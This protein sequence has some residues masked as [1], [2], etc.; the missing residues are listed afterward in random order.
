MMC[1][2]RIP[3]NEND[4]VVTNGLTESWGR[5]SC[6][7]VCSTI[8]NFTSE[9]TYLD[10]Q[11]QSE[12]GYMYCRPRFESRICI[13]ADHYGYDAHVRTRLVVEKMKLEGTF[14]LVFGWSG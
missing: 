4:R 13:S 14:V 10:T 2:H 5:R 9:E 11:E 3:S 1:S 8:R 7:L 12:S 6:G